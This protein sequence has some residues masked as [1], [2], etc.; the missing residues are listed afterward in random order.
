MSQNIESLLQESRLF[1]PPPGFAAAAHVK[2]RAEYDAL[3]KQAAADPEGYWAGIAKQLHWFKPWT[4]VLDWKP[5]FAKWFD[6]GT[7]NLSYNCLDRHL[8]GPRRNKTAIL[9]EGEPGD[10]RTLTYEQLHREVSIFAGA[11]K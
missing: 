10:T 3:R 1:D 11:L 8:D 7:T 4:Q 6:G 2:S 9:W 5:P